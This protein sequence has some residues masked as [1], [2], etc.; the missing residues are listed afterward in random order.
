MR[1][2][3]ELLVQLDEVETLE[4]VGGG[5]PPQRPAPP[6]EP[7]VPRLIRHR[8][9]SVVTVLHH[10]LVELTHL[11]PELLLQQKQCSIK[12]KIKYT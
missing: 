11:P 6:V 10:V 3:V 7:H 12:R 4:V 5:C 2:D 1:P 8:P 9:E